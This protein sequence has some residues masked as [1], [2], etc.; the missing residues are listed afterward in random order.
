MV[1]A[2]FAEFIISC[3]AMLTTHGNPP[4]PNP[5]SKPTV[6]QPASTYAP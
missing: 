5:G 3:T 4:P 1:S 6:P 2:M